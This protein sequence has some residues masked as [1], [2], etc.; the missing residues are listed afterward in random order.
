MNDLETS[1]IEIADYESGTQPDELPV[2]KKMPLKVTFDFNFKD[3]LNML[4]EY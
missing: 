4:A 1:E 3:R 2:K